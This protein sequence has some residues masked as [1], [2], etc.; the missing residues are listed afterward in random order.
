[1]QPLYCGYANSKGTLSTQLNYKQFK[2]DNQ[3]ENVFTVIITSSVHVYTS[4]TMHQRRRVIVLKQRSM[5]CDG[6]VSFFITK[7]CYEVINIDSQS[8][9]RE[10]PTA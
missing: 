5:Q 9:T 8:S 10:K 2:A 7:F 1:M 3:R 6:S 4:D